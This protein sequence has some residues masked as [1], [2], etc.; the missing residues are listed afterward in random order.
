M[1][2]PEDVMTVSFPRP[3]RDLHQVPPR[4]DIAPDREAPA[5]LAGDLTQNGQI[6]Y[7]RHHDQVYTLRITRAGKL[8]LTK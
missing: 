5:Y 8:I 3:P 7:I 1:P 2:D 6:A 4:A